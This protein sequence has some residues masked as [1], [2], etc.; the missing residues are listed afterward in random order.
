MKKFF[1][2]SI[3]FISSPLLAA[4]ITGAGSGGGGGGGSGDITGVEAG[5]GLSGGGTSGDVTLDLETDVTNYIQNRDT[6]Q[7][8]STFYVSRATIFGRLNIQNAP[9]GSGGGKLV[10]DPGAVGST[11]QLQLIQ[12]TG[13]APAGLINFMTL[14]ST[15]SAFGVSS[16][17]FDLLQA[18]SGSSGYDVSRITFLGSSPRVTFGGNNEGF[19]LGQASFTFIQDGTTFDPI[20][21]WPGSSPGLLTLSTG[22][23]ALKDLRYNDDDSSN[24]VGHRAS[25]TVASNFT[26][27][28][29][30][31]P[32]TVGQIRKVVNVDGTDVYEEYANIPAK[33]FEWSGSGTLPVDAAD[34]IAAISKSTG[35][36]FDQL[37]AAYDSSTDE[38][39]SIVFSVPEEINTSTTVTLSVYWIAT[40]TFGA[41]VW[42]FRHNSGVTSGVNPIS[43]SVTTVTASAA[44]TQGTAGQLN[45]TT[46][47]ETVSN[48]GWVADDQVNA[49]FCRD[50]NHASDTM[51][52]DAYATL[53]KVKIPRIALP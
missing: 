5:Y 13:G 31:A 3:I 18:T 30:D 53:F 34:K 50:A 14:T 49:E 45:I 19:T 48:L 1:F 11:P 46:W 16:S 2:I 32:G 40:A 22:A 8:G 10:F 37:L 23:F 35:T 27:V 41:T 36:Y 44:T 15:I 7:E 6:L 21:S 28:D 20:L 43:V 24:Y 38:C 47:T 52:G 12:N 4:R 51:T 39:R 9:D 17:G 33:L 29:P 42:D 26:I 25:A